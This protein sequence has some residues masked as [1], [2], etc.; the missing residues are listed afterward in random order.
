LQGRLRIEPFLQKW[1]L[2]AILAVR[3]LIWRLA[4]LNLSFDRL[5]GYGRGG[6]VVPDENG[7]DLEKT[8]Y[9]HVTRPRVS[10][11]LKELAN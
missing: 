7:S 8:I 11:T 2:V 3:R 5:E 4:L 9:I 1:R 6:V 10:A